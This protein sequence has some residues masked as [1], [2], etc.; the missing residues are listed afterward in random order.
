MSAETLV[1][2][3]AAIFTT[4]AFLPQAIH[5]IRHKQTAGISLLM[6]AILAT[7]VFFWIVFGVMIEN[8]PV[9]VADGIT[10]TFT[11]IIIA[12]KLKHG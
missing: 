4:T 8:W 5:I 11:L 3:I 1:S 9:I 6:Y 10:L 12:L 2:A 7:G